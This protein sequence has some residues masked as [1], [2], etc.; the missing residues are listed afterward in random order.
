MPIASLEPVIHKVQ[1]TWAGCLEWLGWT[2]GRGYGLVK[3]DSRVSY[4]HRYVYSVTVGDIPAGLELDHL[5]RNPICVRPDHLEPVTH[6]ENM[7][8]GV[9]PAARRAV[10]SHC[11]R[12]HPFDEAN[13][14]KRKD[15]HGH[16][17][18]RR[19]K[20]DSMQRLR[21]RRKNGD[22]Q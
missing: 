1:P 22:E 19:C 14:Y 13:T 11:E 15:G 5:C 10:A 18:C 8:R 7:L 4:A 9:N 2:N 17:E 6:R 16:R 20:A 12:G 21:D 3:V